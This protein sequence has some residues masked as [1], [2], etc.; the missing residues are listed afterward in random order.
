MILFF[1]HGGI[2]LPRAQALHRENI[3]PVVEE[4]LLKVVLNTIALTLTLF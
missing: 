1:S 4:A 2:V 3:R